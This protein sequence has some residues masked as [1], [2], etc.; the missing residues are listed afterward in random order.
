VPDDVIVLEIDKLKKASR[1]PDPDAYTQAKYF[2]YN[3]E[4]DASAIAELQRLRQSGAELP[5]GVKY[6]SAIKETDE[7]ARL[8]AIQKQ[9]SGLFPKLDVRSSF[10]A[11][12]A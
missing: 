11:R 10:S 1:N 3:P 9:L 6:V 8:A 7:A 2:T 12:A 4:T 5:K